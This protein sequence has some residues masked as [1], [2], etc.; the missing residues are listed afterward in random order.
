MKEEEYQMPFRSSHGNYFENKMT[1]ILKYDKSKAD[2][3]IYA[4]LSKTPPHPSL[5]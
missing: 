2:H 5:V 4:F 1:I 3:S